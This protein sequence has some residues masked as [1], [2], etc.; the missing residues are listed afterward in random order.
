MIRNLG[1]CCSSCARGKMGDAA[2]DP[3]ANV[4]MDSTGTYSLP[5]AIDPYANYAADS[6]GTFTAPTSLTTPA[7]TSSNSGLIIIGALV[8]AA[9]LLGRR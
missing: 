2:V 8:G 1:S 9:L 6:T 5:V 3:Y 7:A 4:A